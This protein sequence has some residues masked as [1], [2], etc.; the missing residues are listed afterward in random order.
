MEGQNNGLDNKKLVVILA[1]AGVLGGGYYYYHINN[2]K[3]NAKSRLV[4]MK[5]KLK[6]KV[7]DGVH[8]KIDG[9]KDKMRAKQEI[10]DTPTVAID[11]KNA[12]ENKII[13]VS[14]PNG[15]IQINNLPVSAKNADILLMA[16]VQ[17][18]DLARAKSLVESGVS[19]NFTNNKIC[20]QFDK[21]N[22]TLEV[23]ANT[24]QLKSAVNG[25][26]SRGGYVLMTDCTKLFLL[27]STDGMRL[28]SEND[29]TFTINNYGFSDEQLALPDT[30][31]VKQNYLRLKAKDLE[32]IQAQQK[33]EDMFNF[34]LDNT[35]FFLNSNY[36]QLPYIY[37]DSR[38]PYSVRVKALKAYIE[39]QSNPSKIKHV[40]N[41]DAFNSL[42]KEL[43][44]NISTNAQAGSFNAEQSAVVKNEIEN[45]SKAGDLMD[46]DFKLVVNEFVKNAGQYVQITRDLAPTGGSAPYL[47]NAG[48][49][50]QSDLELSL[51]ALK[52]DGISYQ[53]NKQNML[54]HTNLGGSGFYAVEETNLLAP[55]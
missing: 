3:E 11:T 8:N 33:K 44:N 25:Q 23:P 52:Q 47:K 41:V 55:T 30:H 19:L 15:F 17:S 31:P 1:L 14:N 39:V 21:A 37:R 26:G 34:L 36:S 16:A 20:V 48:I 45:D 10:Y 42:A 22:N 54:A 5:D 50:Y 2:V 46:A 49:G 29:E 12:G 28:P 40:A 7:K 51:N 43:V 13:D 4:A 24:E 18:G 27:A 32:V 9:I 6:D 53:K 38:L 35:N